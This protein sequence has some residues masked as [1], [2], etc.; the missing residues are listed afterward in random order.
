M[1]KDLMCPTTQSTSH[2]PLKAAKI[3]TLFPKHVE[4]SG[5]SFLHPRVQKSRWTGSLPYRSV[6]GTGSPWP[7]DLHTEGSE[8]LG[9]LQQHNKALILGQSHV[10]GGRMSAARSR[11]HLL[12]MTRANCIE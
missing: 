5:T 10:A 8:V 11:L 1:W 7:Q 9:G 4:P 3:L 2:W 6:S 12:G